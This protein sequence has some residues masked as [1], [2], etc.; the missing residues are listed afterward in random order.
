M[1]T[2]TANNNSTLEVLSVVTRPVTILVHHGWRR[3]FLE[4]PKFFKVCLIV[5]NYAQQ[6]FPGVAKN[7]AEG[8]KPPSPQ[9]T[10]LAVTNGFIGSYGVEV[11]S[12]E[13]K[14]ESFRTLLFH[15]TEFY[16]YDLMFSSKVFAHA[17]E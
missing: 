7:F 15:I 2:R 3:V 6:I 17:T 4:G 9:V 16:N 14:L 1:C 8:A 13:M 5:F 10:G 12:G 11:S